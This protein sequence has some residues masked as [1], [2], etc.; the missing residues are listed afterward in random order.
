[1]IFD[2]VNY[3]KAED[4][5]SLL[6][7]DLIS[8]ILSN[9]QADS[10]IDNNEKIPTLDVAELLQLENSLD[11]QVVSYISRHSAPLAILVSILKLPFTNN[12]NE[13][14]TYA[15]TNSKEFPVLF[16]WICTKLYG[17]QLL[18]LP[19]QLTLTH[20]IYSYYSTPPSSSATTNSNQR[21]SKL[22]TSISYSQL[23]L[24]SEELASLQDTTKFLELLIHENINVEQE[25]H[26]K[27][28]T[29]LFFFI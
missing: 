7:L 6:N 28:H 25:F 13:F 23:P 11:L 18:N 29:L 16:N 27:V 10:G 15:L 24:S 9:N 8:I 21:N 26:V 1:L 4:I 19:S 5:A 2:T 3:Q 12:I 14:L 20:G 22:L 17:F